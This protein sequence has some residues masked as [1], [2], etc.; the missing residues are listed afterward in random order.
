MMIRALLLFIVGFALTFGARFA[1]H[2][3]EATQTDL[4]NAKRLDA[5][6]NA[7]GDNPYASEILPILANRQR[8]GR[9][10][11]LDAARVNHVC[12]AWFDSEPAECA[13]FLKSMNCM[14][15]LP[16]K[17]DVSKDFRERFHEIATI[18]DSLIRNAQ[19]LSVLRHAPLSQAKDAIEL[20]NALPSNIRFQ[21]LDQMRKRWATTDSVGAFN[22]LIVNGIKSQM[23]IER[24]IDDAS[25]K[26]PV[27]LIQAIEAMGD[28]WFENVSGMSRR[29]FLV[30]VVS[31]ARD[32]DIGN[33]LDAT[34]RLES[35]ALRA[36]LLPSSAA[37]AL[38]NG[39]D[40]SGVWGQCSHAERE[41]ILSSAAIFY[42]KGDTSKISAQLE[43]LTDGPFKT[44]SYVAAG[45]HI[46]VNNPSKALE[47]GL[48]LEN[49]VVRSAVSRTVF[50]SWMQQDVGKALSKVISMGT[51]HPRAVEVQAIAKT[52]LLNIAYNSKS[53]SRANAVEGF[54]KLDT[55]TRIGLQI[56][57]KA[58]LEPQAAAELE[59]LIT[60]GK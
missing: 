26:Q 1:A 7:F 55:K 2:Q 51:D 45:K 16:T 28:E 3:R 42:S 8:V 59:K 12:E 33:V 5:T 18:E 40:I 48:G 9:A 41:S 43:R 10:H 56:A 57:V 54:K 4:E 13:R 53:E 19:Y 60:N 21:A 22:A 46:A 44:Q 37:K 38:A 52:E 47:W 32:K 23:L 15:F 14:E 11:P 17:D 35:D 49:P 6:R 20:A 50:A 31:S 27:E 36:Y 34:L 58:L 24:A 30:N 29:S 25:E 39:V